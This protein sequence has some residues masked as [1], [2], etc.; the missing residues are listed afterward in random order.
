M[1]DFMKIIENK[2]SFSNCEGKPCA[3][4]GFSSAEGDVEVNGVTVNAVSCKTGFMGLGKGAIDC[5]KAKDIYAARKVQNANLQANSG[6]KNFSMDSAIQAQTQ[7]LTTTQSEVSKN[8]QA[9]KPVASTFS[10]SSFSTM[11]DLRKSYIG[12]SSQPSKPIEA[13]NALVRNATVG[14]TAGGLTRQEQ[15]AQKKS[16]LTL[17]SVFSGAKEGLSFASLFKKEDTTNHV[18]TPQA[19]TKTESTETPKMEL[20]D[21][22]VFMGIRLKKTAW[23]VIFGII[24]LAVVGIGIY[25][26]TKK[27]DGNISV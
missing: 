5:R 9:S 27:D 4:N 8:I 23:Q 24:A 18:I 20:V 16:G 26:L 25:F 22:L 17:D 7:K 19:E 11:D 1:Q 6:Y 13:N 10:S 14:V 21:D 15:D 12:I 2:D 3:C